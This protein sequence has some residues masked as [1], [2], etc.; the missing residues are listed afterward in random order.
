M[1][2]KLVDMV[3][4]ILC[5]GSRIRGIGRAQWNNNFE[6][7]VPSSSKGNG[8]PKLSALDRLAF[9]EKGNDKDSATQK[10]E[11]NPK[12]AKEKISTDLVVDSSKVNLKDENLDYGDEYFED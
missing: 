1:N 9:L 11:V 2:I 5:S 7:Q 4:V 8:A 12:K 10:L 6:N 3:E